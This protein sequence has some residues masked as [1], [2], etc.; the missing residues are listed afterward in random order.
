MVNRQMN[1]SRLAKLPYTTNYF[2]GN[3][4]YFAL[5]H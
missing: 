4:L 5:L 3:H 1:P 2:A